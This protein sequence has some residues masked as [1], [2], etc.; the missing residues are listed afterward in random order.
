MLRGDNGV[1]RKGQRGRKGWAGEKNL[2][3]HVNPPPTCMESSLPSTRGW[4]QCTC[5]SSLLLLSLTLSLSLSF[6]FYILT[7]RDPF[8]VPITRPTHLIHPS[9]STH[10]RVCKNAVLS[11]FLFSPPPPLFLCV[12]DVW[13]WDIAFKYWETQLMLSLAFDACLRAGQ[14]GGQQF[15]G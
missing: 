8:S 11:P 3:M 4:V 10:I 6:F 12:C 14:K 7:H 9:T 13:L 5:S 2:N 1:E 15:T